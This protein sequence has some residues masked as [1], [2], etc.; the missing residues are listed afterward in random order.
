MTGAR[1]GGAAVYAFV[2]DLVNRRLPPGGE[3]LEVGCGAMQYAPLVNGS[4]RGLDLPTSSHVVEQPHVVA[5]IEEMP[6][7]DESFD[8]V[9]GVAV[10]YLVADVRRALAECRRVLRRGGWLILFDYR[11]AT[12]QA[13][14]DGGDPAARQ[15]WTGPELR[16]LVRAT[17]FHRVRELSHRAAAGGD[18]PLRRRVV[19]RMKA[20]LDPD[21]TQWL[22]VE[23]RRPTR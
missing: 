4:Y 23:A 20:A 22:V 6:L 15:L 13:M 21:R 3:V 7:A 19:R 8:V 9:F 5:S 2:A 10:F 12:V 11:A 18:P 14:I 16:D 17:G 1:L